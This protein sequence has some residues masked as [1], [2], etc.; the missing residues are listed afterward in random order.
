[1]LLL[2]PPNYKREDH[3]ESRLD[4]MYTPRTEEYLNKLALEIVQER[5]FLSSMIMREENIPMV[6]MALALADQRMIHYLRSTGAWL[7]YEY[8]DKAAPRSINGYPCFF[9][10]N[11][12]NKTD[13]DRLVVKMEKLKTAM[14]AALE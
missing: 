5:V 10:F 1:M 14:S 3:L 9:S 8:Y 11:F 13:T 2:S 4:S 12:L 6:F 7:L